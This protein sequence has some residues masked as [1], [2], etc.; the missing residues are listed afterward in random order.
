[1]VARKAL[2]IQ[3]T[4]SS[5]QTVANYNIISYPWLHVASTIMYALAKGLVSL[6]EGKKTP[7]ALTEL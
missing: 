4:I 5:L 1:M 7:E 3:A 2:N 6:S